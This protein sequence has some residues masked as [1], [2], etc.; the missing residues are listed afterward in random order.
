MTTSIDTVD[1]AN[2][3]LSRTAS[4]T[5]ALSASGTHHSPDTEII[6]LLS[7]D[8]TS[9]NPSPSPSP[10][11][12]SCNSIQLLSHVKAASP[13]P[14]SALVDEKPKPR[15][16]SSVRTRLTDT[17]QAQIVSL[18]AAGWNFT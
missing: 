10:S 7:D 11:T 12:A 13:S 14:F 18:R 5:P 16:R 9:R 1:D 2:L 6:S 17:E 4:P 8:T 15:T 3:I